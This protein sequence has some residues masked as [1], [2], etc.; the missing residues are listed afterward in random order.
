MSIPGV[1]EWLGVAVG[2]DWLQP[3]NREPDR[4]IAR[5]TQPDSIAFFINI[6]SF[7]CADGPTIRG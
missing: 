6:P 4:P 3:I 7:C 5:N 1:I 2:L